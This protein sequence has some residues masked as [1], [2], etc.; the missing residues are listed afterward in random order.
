VKY[1][2]GS[3]TD[4]VQGIEGSQG[5]SAIYDTKND[6]NKYEDGAGKCHQIQQLGTPGLYIWHKGID[7][8]INN[9]VPGFSY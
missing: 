5:I 7:P 2:Q 6:E 8:H 1:Q 3:G 9:I 4:Q